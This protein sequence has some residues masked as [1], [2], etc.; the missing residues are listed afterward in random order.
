MLFFFLIRLS[1]HWKG[2]CL[3]SCL[4]KTLSEPL[5]GSCHPD[6]KITFW[7]VV[8]RWLLALSIP[9]CYF[10]TGHVRVI[11]AAQRRWLFPEWLRTS[12]LVP[13]AV[14][15]TFGGG[16]HE[17]LVTS[18]ESWQK[19]VVC[20]GLGVTPGH[21]WAGGQSSASRSSLCGLWEVISWLLLSWVC[22]REAVRQP[23]LCGHGH[24]NDSQLQ[25][26]NV[27]SRKCHFGVSPVL[28]W[29]RT[30]DEEEVTQAGRFKGG[31]RCL[32]NLAKKHRRLTAVFLTIVCSLWK[33]NSENS[34]FSA[35]SL[36]C[37]VACHQRVLHRDFI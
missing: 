29:G 34:E 17:T 21:C 25:L 15:S 12:E 4:Q 18:W 30:L 35:L 31:A 33:K 7:V 13:S 22:G 5:F 3:G 9:L 1:F 37:R 20:I 23:R 2:G 32:R 14:A 28:C 16:T 27:E 26:F 11:T 24:A 10:C 19:P 6:W 8:E 36:N